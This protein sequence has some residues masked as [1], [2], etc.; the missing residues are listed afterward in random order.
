MPTKSHATRIEEAALREVVP[1]AGS[2]DPRYLEGVL[3][4][5]ALAL[6]SIDKNGDQR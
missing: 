6:R 5:L 4:G 2:V 3:A 1:M